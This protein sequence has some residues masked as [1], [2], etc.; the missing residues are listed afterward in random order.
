[1]WLEY[2]TRTRERRLEFSLFLSPLQAF[3]EVK[4]KRT[5]N[6]AL[7]SLVER[8]GKNIISGSYVRGRGASLSG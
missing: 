2:Q 6:S 3:C 7:T 4:V 8:W 1:M 5:L